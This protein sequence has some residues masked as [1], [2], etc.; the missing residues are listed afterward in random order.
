VSFLNIRHLL[1]FGLFLA[2]SAFIDPSVSYSQNHSLSYFLNQAYNNDPQIASSQ[3]NIKI[4]D[5]GKRINKAMFQKPVISG[6]GMALYAPGTSKWGFGKAI[7]NGG[8]YDALLNL[9]Y[10]LW[11]SK[12]LRAYN[13]QSN[14]KARRAN[15][16][17]KLRKHNLK[18]Q[19]TQAY[20]HVYGD[21][22]NIRYLHNLHQLLQQQINQL[23]SL[24]KSGIIKIT[25]LQQ[26]RLEDSQI[27]IQLKQAKNQL[28]KDQSS[29][30]QLCGIQDTTIYTI[31]NPG[32]QVP[33][34]SKKLENVRSSRF[35]HSYGI[36]SL[37]VEAQQKIR[38]TKYLPQ[39][40]AVAN[41]G[42]ST[43][44]LGDAAN[45]FGFSLGLQLHWRLWDGHQQSLQRQ[46]TKLNLENIQDHRKFE[47]RRLY[48]QRNSLMNTLK[49]V[50]D[51]ITDQKKQVSDYSDLLNAYRTE[52]D[53]GIQSVTSY[54][55]VFRQYLNAKN[56]LNNLNIQRL[57]TINDL[58]YWNW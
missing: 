16:N 48:Q 10:P 42:L 4:A 36:D 45:R 33:S 26:V 39:I 38:D 29:M 35:L 55:T 57:Q 24:V 41:T 44:N 12:D 49:D 3:R 19:V 46:Q 8:E 1:I 53:K 30:N 15:Y 47:K 23:S 2:S 54:V 43:S 6:N 40:S 18:F 9:T 50:Q 25:D 28:V 34:L 22:E 58:N 56:K 11:Q 20:I 7:T 32:L 27:R 14:S 13:L 31:A 17:L 21:Q 37:S 51:Q 5:L 52:I